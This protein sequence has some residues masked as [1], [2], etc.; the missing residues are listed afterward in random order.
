M[1]NLLTKIL[2]V[3]ADLQPVAKDLTNPY[4]KSRYFDV[5]S[6][7]DELRPLLCL[8]KLVV[9]QPLTSENGAICLTTIVADPE[10]GESMEFKTPLP[11]NPDP[12][13]QGSIV[14]YFR[15][16]ALVS[17]FLMQGELDDDGNSAAKTLT[18]EVT[19]TAGRKKMLQGM[20]DRADAMSKE[21][22]NAAY[23]KMIIMAGYD[24]KDLAFVF[25][26][27]V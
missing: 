3:Q 15:R 23:E 17:L 24:E 1:K 26:D 9:I 4:F 5:N 10:S 14:T 21:E 25:P 19:M 13:K 18:E 11:D 7:I 2:A 16:Y 8:K 22:R 20:K 27:L 6:V 12:Q